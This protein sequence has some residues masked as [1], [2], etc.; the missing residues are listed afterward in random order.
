MNLEAVRFNKGSWNEVIGL[1]QDAHILQTWEWGIVKGQYGWK[2]NPY[3]W[4][5]E[6]GLIV[7]AALILQRKIP[8]PGIKGYRSILYVPKGPLLDWKDRNI[9]VAVLK[10][11]I[12]LS[13]DL[14]GIFIKIDPDIYLGTGLEGESDF[15]KNEEGLTVVSDLKKL[16]WLFSQEQIQ[17]KNTVLIDLCP[18]EDKLLANMKQKTRYNIRLAGRKG[19][20][21]RIGDLSDIDMLYQMYLETSVRD[22]FVIRSE[23]YYRNL[24]TT[25]IQAGLAVPLIAEVDNEPIAALILFIFRKRAWYLYGMSRKI[26]RSKMPNYL[27]QWEAIKRSKDAGCEIYD[28]W[29]APESMDKRDALQG[30]YRFKSGFGG[31]LVRYLGAWDYEISPALY[32]IYTKVVPN[33]LSIARSRGIVVARKEVDK[34]NQM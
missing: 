11:L 7:A 6:R 23:E 12:N 22:Q 26:H 14:G 10:S 1:F 19:V 21:V 4:R 3:F 9:R 18:S 32:N 25:F 2:V 29:G 30:V 20:K 34:T 8:I 24:W 27:L 31:T 15:S 28:M 13:K 17:F 16:G 33:V 5:N